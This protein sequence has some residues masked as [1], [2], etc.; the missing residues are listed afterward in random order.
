MT[1]CEILHSIDDFMVAHSQELPG[2]TQPGSYSV[3]MKMYDG[4]KQELTC[5]ALR[6]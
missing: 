4:M 3:K 1:I 6:F 5:I 2:F